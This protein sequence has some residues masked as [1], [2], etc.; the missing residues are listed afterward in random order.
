MLG[1]V[2]LLQG[3]YPL[4]LPPVH[5]FSPAGTL[6]VGQGGFHASLWTGLLWLDLQL[7]CNLPPGP[8]F[9]DVIAI[10]I[11][12]SFRLCFVLVS[13]DIQGRICEFIVW[14][15]FG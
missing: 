11:C 15:F 9:F 13:D 3:T 10:I 2:C 12:R 8:A 5:N 6:S 4:F 1:V 14:T 7:Y